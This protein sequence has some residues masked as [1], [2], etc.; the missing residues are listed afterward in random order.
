MHTDSEKEEIVQTLKLQCMVQTMATEL[1]IQVQQY[2][3]KAKVLEE[4]KSFAKVFSK[5][6]SKRYPLRITRSNSKRM[7][8]MQ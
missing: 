7:H 3:T 1:A 2:T 6:E 4:Y 5:E 8:Q